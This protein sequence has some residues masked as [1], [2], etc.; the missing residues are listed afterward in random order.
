MEKS[1]LAQISE[2]A[3]KK[4]RKMFSAALIFFIIIGGVL[5]FALKSS[6]D[7]NDPE[8]KKL[9]VMLI[10]LAAVMLLSCTVGLIGSLRTATKGQ[11]LILPFNEDTKEN[12]AKLIDSEAANG[13]LL[14][15][16]YISDF[17]DGRKPSGEKI[18]LTA[19]YLLLNNGLGKVKA[20]P[21][22]K[23]YW[24]CA[25]VG[26]KGQSSFVVRIL[27]FTEKSTYYVDGVDVKH[28]EDIA[29]KLYQHI[30]NIFSEYN[31]F[32]FSYQLETIFEKDRPQ[33]MKLYEEARSKTAEQ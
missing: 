17:S 3:N 9:V 12:V 5:F 18:A 14:V 7:M 2:T 16:E 1:Y 28:V 15:D 31:P 27:V 6:L 4:K 11:C 24:L 29:E 21:R 13:K 19:T 33:F 32:I 25:Q 8:D 23:I 26:R 10:G 22:D 30:P 20:I